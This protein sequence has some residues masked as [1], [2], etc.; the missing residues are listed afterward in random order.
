MLFRRAACLS[1]LISA[2]LVT[3]AHAVTVGREQDIVD[4]KLGQRVQVDDGTCP[5]GQVKEVRGTKMTD[6]GVARTSACVP[7]YGPK[8]K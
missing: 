5:A 7:R 1:V 2:A 4:L 3:T 8:T 6:K